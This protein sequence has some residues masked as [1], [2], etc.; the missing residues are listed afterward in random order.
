MFRQLPGQKR[1]ENEEYELHDESGLILQHDGDF[2][3]RSGAIIYMSV[4]LHMPSFLQNQNA[5]PRCGVI[6][7]HPALG[8]KLVQWYVL[9]KT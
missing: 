1:I 5:C 2:I 8:Q 3:S 6:R 7:A 9:H 4:V